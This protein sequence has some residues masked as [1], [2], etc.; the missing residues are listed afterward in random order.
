VHRVAHFVFGNTSR[1]STTNST[2]MSLVPTKE[3][4]AVPTGYGPRFTKPNDCF[5]AP[6]IRFSRREIDKA[7]RVA[8]TVISPMLRS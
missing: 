5:G 4:R 8:R 3:Q 2:G 7:V 6:E 1:C